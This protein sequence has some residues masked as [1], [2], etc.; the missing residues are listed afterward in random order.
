MAS[1]SLVAVILSHMPVTLPPWTV[2]TLSTT[3]LLLS[4][5]LLRLL[6]ILCIT[7]GIFS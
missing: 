6:C 2:L 7:G 1:Y 4:G 5:S 3:N